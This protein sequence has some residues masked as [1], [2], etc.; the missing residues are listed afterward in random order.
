MNYS[1]PYRDLYNWSVNDPTSFWQGQAEAIHWQ[2]P[3]DTVCDFSNPP[4]KFIRN[5]KFDANH[6]HRLP[7]PAGAL[8][9]D[10]SSV[11]YRSGREVKT[12][13]PRKILMCPSQ[14][15]VISGTV[16]SAGSSKESM[17][18]AQP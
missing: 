1:S 16:N 14:H 18:E 2:T 17:M 9:A 10:G 11:C 3:F 15:H 5:P 4:W 13:I 8:H 7:K 12:E 6:M